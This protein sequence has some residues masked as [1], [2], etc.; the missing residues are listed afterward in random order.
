MWLGSQWAH[1]SAISEQK[2]ET[3]TH[4]SSGPKMIEKAGGTD[5]LS[6]CK[7]KEKHFASLGPPVQ[8]APS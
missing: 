5:L 2:G 8:K 3:F 4:G 7:A 6:S 1:S